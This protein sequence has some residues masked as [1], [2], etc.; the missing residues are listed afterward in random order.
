ML[1]SNLRALRGMSTSGLGTGGEAHLDI[2][3]LM[4]CNTVIAYCSDG[5]RDE[6]IIFKKVSISGFY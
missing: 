3:T 4:S 1:G 6:L 5:C 2:F